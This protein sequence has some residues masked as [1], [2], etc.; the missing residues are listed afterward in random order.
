MS[1]TFSIALF[2]RAKRDF[3]NNHFKEFAQQIFELC[4][5]ERIEP[6]YLNIEFINGKSSQLNLPNFKKRLL[7]LENNDLNYL[8]IIKAKSDFSYLLL[9]WVIST[10]IT[11][12]E[13]INQIYFGI[14]IEELTLLYE[15]K[16]QILSTLLDFI[17]V[18]YGFC[19]H[20]DSK[21]APSA[22]VSGMHVST[23]SESMSKFESESISVWSNYLP[24]SIDS[25]ANG[26][27]RYL[28]ES[29]II[30]H[31]HLK[32]KVFG[33]Y[34]GDWILKSPEYGYLKPLNEK[35]FLWTIN[36]K[37]LEQLRNLFINENCFL[38]DQNIKPNFD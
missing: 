13:N 16:F 38:L 15:E 2:G 37:N 10:S 26:K 3:R 18:E 35:L 31:F 30:N 34:L 9:D 21:Y 23:Q 28:Y 6:D 22:Y 8:S 36:Q 7:K 4:Q 5:K 19:F 29:N 11:C 25:V 33:F 12:D 1:K 20:S 17:E 14:D 27:F 32:R 24:K